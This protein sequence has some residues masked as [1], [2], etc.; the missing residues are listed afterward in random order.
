MTISLAIQTAGTCENFVKLMNEKAKSIGMKNS[1]FNNPHGL[2]DNTENYSTAYDMAL[3]SKYA[4]QNPI[5]RKIVSTKKYTT[6]TNKKTYIWYNRNKLLNNYQ[7]CTGGKNGYTPKASKTLVTTAS[8]EGLN[9]TIVSLHDYD[10]YSTHKKLYEELLNEYRNYLIIDKNKFNH[11]NNNNL[12]LKESFYYPLKEEEKDTIKT[13][14]NIEQKSKN[15]ITGKIN[16]YLK[17]NKIG[18]LNI[19]QRKKTPKKKTLYQKIKKL[20]TRKSK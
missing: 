14:V 3:L 10:T 15:N 19:Y 13:L 4:Y 5:Y 9:L 20:F 11:Q 7:Y 8:K 16:I 17:D 6:K 18:Q 1:F 12:Y 2:D